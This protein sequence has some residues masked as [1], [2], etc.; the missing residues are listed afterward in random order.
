MYI[1]LKRQSVVANAFKESGDHL[2]S[3]V[4]EYTYKYA[5]ECMRENVYVTD[6]HV[7]YT[8]LGWVYLCVSQGELG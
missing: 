4:G 5:M 6:V 7:D 2:S 1:I 3:Q 8:Y